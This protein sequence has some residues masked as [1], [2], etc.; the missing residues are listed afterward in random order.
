MKAEQTARRL[1]QTRKEGI[2]VT[3]VM[4]SKERKAGSKLEGDATHILYE[5][6]SSVFR[7]GFRKT[8]PLKGQ[9]MAARRA[10]VVKGCRAKREVI[11]SLPL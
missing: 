8:S 5:H 6:M 10:E 4:Q 2:V 9:K 11:A 3:G 1:L 7:G